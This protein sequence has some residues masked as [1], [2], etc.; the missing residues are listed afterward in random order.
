[1]LDMVADMVP[2]FSDKTRTVCVC[3]RVGRRVWLGTSH[4]TYE[5]KASRTPPKALTSQARIGQIRLETLHTRTSLTHR[6]PSPAGLA[7]QTRTCMGTLRLKLKSDY[8]V[9]EPM[10]RSCS[11]LVYVYTL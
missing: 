3:G 10:C 7:S 2:P 6:N 4:K 1:M 8:R 5:P 9:S 11:Q